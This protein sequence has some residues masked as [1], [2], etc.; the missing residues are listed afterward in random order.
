MNAARD[1]AGAAQPALYAMAKKGELSVPVIGVASTVLTLEQVQQRVRASIE[2]EGGIDDAAAFDKL[3]SLVHYVSGDYADPA[4]LERLKVEIG[5][6]KRTAHYLAIAPAL[7]E[8]V[9]S[10]LGT[11][12][13]AKDAR[14]IVEK[15]FGCALRLFIESWRWAGVPWYLRTGKCLPTTAAEVLV[16]LKAPPQRLFTSQDAVEAA[17]AVVDDV[18]EHHHPALQ[19]A[20]GSW[21]PPAADTLI[22][23]DGGWH[24]LTATEGCPP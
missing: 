9:I 20:R 24:A 2:H 21:G 19:Y 18:L 11:A 10:S 6:A 1:K 8:T 17:W 3:L 4:T 16:Q 15:P 7:F 13:L 22:A 12:G 23:R 5:A 14:V